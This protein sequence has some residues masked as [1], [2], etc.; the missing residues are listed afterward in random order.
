M[1]LVSEAPAGGCSVMAPWDQAAL[2]RAEVSL[3][4]ERIHEA[5][6]PNARP[7]AP[8]RRG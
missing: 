5:V 3:R 1:L 7:G 8:Q 4:L 2:I 6:L